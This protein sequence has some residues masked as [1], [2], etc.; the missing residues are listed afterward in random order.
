MNGVSGPLVD[1][2][3]A[4]L[5]YALCIAW[6][7]TAAVLHAFVRGPWS[8]GTCRFLLGMG[9]AGNWPAAVKVAADENM[10]TWPHS[11]PRT[12]T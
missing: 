3:G 11:G 6:W 10:R 9:E 5:G 4:R 1:R 7:S 2:L 8:L 12:R